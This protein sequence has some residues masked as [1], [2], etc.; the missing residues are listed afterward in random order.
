MSR[1]ADHLPAGG[2]VEEA[3]G[4]LVRPYALIQGRTRTPTTVDLIALVTATGTPPPAT[5]YLGPEHLSIIRLCGRR[6]LSV[7]E[8]SVHL[9]VPLGAVRVLLG[10]LAELDLVRLNDPVPDVVPN[11]V[12]AKVLAGL[13]QL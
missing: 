6:P 11:D 7:A 5:A 3:A 12:L 4:P 13:R 10:D 8:L 9:A 1:E 2:P